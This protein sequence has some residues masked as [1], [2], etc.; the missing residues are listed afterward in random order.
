M[1]L[2]LVPQR[3]RKREGMPRGWNSV[4]S[5]LSPMDCSPLERAMNSSC[6][7]NVS[8]CPDWSMR[9]SRSSHLLKLLLSIVESTC[10]T[11]SALSNTQSGSL[12]R[13]RFG[14]RFSVPELRWCC[15]VQTHL[16]IIVACV[17]EMTLTMTR[18]HRGFSVIAV[19]PGVIRCSMHA[20]SHGSIR[21]HQG[22][23]GVSNEE[24]KARKNHQCPFCALLDLNFIK[25]E[26][27]KIDSSDKKPNSAHKA[28]CFMLNS[29]VI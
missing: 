29:R 26:V 10:T 6:G 4:V 15:P 12:T 20:V 1:A 8:R 7:A 22:C 14:T 11:R 27:E 13:P 3:A 17:E 23:V 16:F 2:R 28:H 19:R 9:S 18:M 25:T 5:T 21:L 24:A